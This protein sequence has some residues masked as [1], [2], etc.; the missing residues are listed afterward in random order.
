MSEAPADTWARVFA[1]L[2]SLQGQIAA[3]DGK[4]GVAIARVEGEIK[5]LRDCLGERCETRGRAMDDLADAQDSLAARLTRLEHDRAVVVGAAG[6]VGGLLGLLGSVI[7][8]YLP[9]GGGH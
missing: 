3:L 1:R 6:V 5:S 2:D 8:R 4:N 9:T 7:L